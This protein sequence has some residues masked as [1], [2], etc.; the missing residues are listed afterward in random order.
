MQSLLFSK[1]LFLLDSTTFPIWGRKS[2]PDI[3]GTKLVY[4]GNHFLLQ[5]ITELSTQSDINLILVNYNFTIKPETVKIFQC[6]YSGITAGKHISN[7]GSGTNTL[8]MPHDPDS[9]PSEFP[10][11][12]YS[13]YYGYLWGAE[14]QFTY[15][16]VAVDDDVPCAICT[17]KPATTTMMIPAKNT[18]PQDWTLQYHGYLSASYSSG[19]S[20]D[21]IC[22][23]NDPE[24]FEGLRQ[25]NSDGHGLYPVKA[26]CGSLPCPN[27]KQSQ[28]LSCAVCSL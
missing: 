18:C 23:D 15:K 1:C 4:T 16:N 3:N 6:S 22:V 26:Y 20:T 25:V 13:G 14:Y 19:K 7:T 8:C 28:Y 10:T 9:L 2:C 24:F 5:Y 27:Y 21:Y 12:T 17:V 11:T